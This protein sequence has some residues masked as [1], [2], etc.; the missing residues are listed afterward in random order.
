LL[1]V[2]NRSGPSRVKYLQ[3]QTG[4]SRPAIY[5]L[6]GILQQ[7]GYADRSPD[8]ALFRLTP[9]IQE[10]CDQVGDND[11]ITAAATP[12]LKRLQKAIVWPTSLAVFEEGAMVIRSTTRISS[13]LVFDRARVGERIPLLNTAVGAAY[14]AFSRAAT[15]HA[16]LN[17]IVHSASD[18]AVPQ[19]LERMKKSI[20]EA[21]RRGY[22]VRRGGTVPNTTSIAVPLISERY[23]VG[24]IVVSY[25]SSALS[26][27]EGSARFVS[28]LQSAA[29]EIS[30]GLKGHS[31]AAPARAETAAPALSD[32]RTKRKRR[33]RAF[34]N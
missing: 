18:G 33:L 29:G 11:R 9:A 13:P 25:L 15:R 23:A 30:E 8:Q 12:V 17:L 10:L 31:I 7:H 32:N 20:A 6:L 2:L 4:I 19:N 28:Q 3:S 34:P 1:K 22:A 5:R 24:S 21:A 26:V 14:L 16:A 27:E